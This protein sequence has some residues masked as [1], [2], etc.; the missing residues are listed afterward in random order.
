M[1]Y[2]QQV[3]ATAILLDLHPEIGEATA[4]NHVAGYDIYSPENVEKTLS[5]VHSEL[6]SH[7]VNNLKVSNA[8]A[9]LA[10]HILL[11]GIAPE[12]LVKD[13]PASL[14]LGSIDWVTLRRA[15]ALAEL[16]APGTSR[17]M[18]YSQVLAFV[19]VEPVNKHLELLNSLTA[20]DPIVDWALIN[21]I[22][23]A[24]ALEQPD[25]QATDKA[26]SAYEQ[27]IGVFAHVADVLSTPLPTR[28]DVGLQVL[29][30]FVPECSFLEEE[31]LLHKNARPFSLFTPPPPSTIVTNAVSTDSSYLAMSPVDLYISHDLASGIWDR[32]TGTSIYE[33]FPRLRTLYPVESTFYENFDTHYTDRKTASIENI[34]LLLSSVPYEDRIYFQRGE[35]SFYTI[36]SSVAV[37]HNSTANSAG[38]SYI[39][40]RRPVLLES[41]KDKDAATGRYG[42][43]MCAYYQ[44]RVICYEVL[45]LQRQCRKNIPLAK[46]II[47]SGTYH[48]P[49]KLAFTENPKAY[50]KPVR[51]LELPVDIECYTHGVEPRQGISS[52][53]VIEKLG[54]LPAPASSTESQRSAYQSYHN[55]PQLDAIAKFIETHRPLATYEE[56]RHQAWGQT[57]LELERETTN[58]R[59]E[60]AIN[61]LVPFKSCIED[62]LSD[63]EEQRAEG[64]LSCT[65][66]AASL[67]FVVIAAA[68]KIVG[69]AT[70]SISAASKAASMAKAAIRLGISV[71]NPLDGA[72]QLLYGG[73]KLL[74][75]GAVRLGKYGLEAL[76]TATFQ[77][78]RLTGS[79]QSYDLI[80][81][82]QRN[83]TVRGIIRTLGNS[84]EDVVVWATR[85]NGQFYAFN[86]THRDIRGGILKE[87]RISDELMH[88][89]LLGKLAPKSYARTIIANGIPIGHRKVDFAIA[90]LNKSVVDSDS[91]LLLKAFFGSDSDDV[92][93]WFL[94]G[95]NAMKEDY[96][97]LSITNIEVKSLGDKM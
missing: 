31:I 45:T 1:M 10:S 26:I 40:T 74:N 70:K 88:V 14:L 17:L 89:P 73:V 85:E 46:L 38:I 18:T 56:L 78:R 51:P 8:T 61:I 2:L 34:K 94:D 7:L 29:K 15:V 42:V 20:L 86:T 87:F 76:D 24:H 55:N 93:E 92:T 79:A 36:R 81:A 90:T 19:E 47:E 9:S 64:V 60:I 41:Q 53:A 21:N 80:K 3:I 50:S 28:K 12:F 48:S 69:I 23:S 63:D 49:S 82:A 25:T 30:T 91:K 59:I 54:E 43:V 52:M 5:S 33:E 27:F 66:E 72:P 35:V 37:E 57:K 32:A 58:N 95:L 77:L 22:I 75:K 11:S 44:G 6:E 4:R 67:I 68:G 96:K 16:N 83:D 97:M 65:L 13:L 62:I 71:L 84:G 39:G